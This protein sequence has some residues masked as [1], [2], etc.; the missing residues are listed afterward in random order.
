MVRK[1]AKESIPEEPML[2]VGEASSNGTH[3]LWNKGHFLDH[4]LAPFEGQAIRQIKRKL[5]SHLLQSAPMES[6]L[7]ELKRFFGVTRPSLQ[8]SG[9]GK[10]P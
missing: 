5:S 3:A 7:L 6:N 2:D 8:S 4:G 9:G 1:L 10:K